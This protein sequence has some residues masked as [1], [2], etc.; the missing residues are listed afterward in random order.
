M[1]NID[2]KLTARERRRAQR[3]ERAGLLSEPQPSTSVVDRNISGS[4]SSSGEEA[5]GSS[6]VAGSTGG[7]DNVR[8]GGHEGQTKRK[9]PDGQKKLNGRNIITPGLASALDRTNTSDRKAVF[10]L[11]E[12]ART[13]P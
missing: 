9:K 3:L 2:H 12:T 11:T 1:S 10:I 8:F 7:D 4:N 5:E 13:R 6:D